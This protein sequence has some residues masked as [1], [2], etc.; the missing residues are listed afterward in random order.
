MCTVH[1][2]AGL[3]LMTMEQCYCGHWPPPISMP[4]LLEPN[5]A[6][7]R[8]FFAVCVEGE[9]ER[10]SLFL[11][12]SCFQIW[13]SFHDFSPPKHFCFWYGRHLDYMGYNWTS[14]SAKM[15]AASFVSTIDGSPWTACHRHKGCCGACD[16]VENGS[17]SIL[18][19]WQWISSKLNGHWCN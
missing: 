13:Y 14:T 2:E 15:G 17:G 12:T 5:R 4:C 10:M 6:G 7:K 1:P 8:V 16:A 19:R 9:R 3:H 11:A 18:T